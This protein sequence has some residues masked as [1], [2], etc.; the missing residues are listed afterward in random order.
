MR[1]DSE[2]AEVGFNVG[3]Q[4]LLPLELWCLKEEEK[5]IDYNRR[6]KQRERKRESK[7]KTFSSEAT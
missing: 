7:A 5:R 1:F 4:V 6:M 2:L 3:V